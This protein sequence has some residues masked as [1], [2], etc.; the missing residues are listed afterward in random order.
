MKILYILILSILIIPLIL[1]E[2]EVY[3]GDAVDQSS[4]EA[5]TDSILDSDYFIYGMIAAIVILVVVIALVL[6][7][8]LS[9][10]AAQPTWQQP[11]FPSRPSYPSGS[12]F[13]PQQTFP[14]QPYSPPQ[15]RFPQTPL[16]PPVQ[17][18]QDPTTV[19]I[20]SCLARGMSKEQIIAALVQNRWTVLQARAAVD[21]YL[22]SRR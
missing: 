11:T 4:T 7:K 16:T 9:K 20:A 8:I 14:Q 6:Y 12:S 10:P 21:K 22:M 18:P 17:Q 3:V 15:Q 13:P 1:A 2:T 19:Y 5:I